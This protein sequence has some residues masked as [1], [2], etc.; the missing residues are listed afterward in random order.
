M[1]SKMVQSQT[2]RL[3]GLLAGHGQVTHLAQDWLNL[4]GGETGGSWGGLS[5]IYSKTGLKQV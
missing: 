1:L 3:E 4:R 2:V 5:D